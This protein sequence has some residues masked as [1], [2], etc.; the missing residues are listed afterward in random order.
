MF[1]LLESVWQLLS[2]Q[3]NGTDHIHTTFIIFTHEDDPEEWSG[4]GVVGGTTNIWRDS[5]S[6]CYYTNSSN[7]INSS[8]GIKRQLRRNTQCKIVHLVLWSVAYDYEGQIWQRNTCNDV[9]IT[10]TEELEEW[11]ID[12]NINFKKT[13]NECGRGK[14]CSEIANQECKLVRVCACDV[15]ICLCEL[16]DRYESTQ[17]HRTIRQWK[18]WVRK[19]TEMSVEKETSCLRNNV[20]SVP[21]NQ[22]KSHQGASG[23]METTGKIPATYGTM[24]PCVQPEVKIYTSIISVWE[25]G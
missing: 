4:T 15:C 14:F 21:E 11:P 16:V 24:K 13:E 6:G 12:V 18:G 5:K 2:T 9:L 19:K 17:T 8:N 10:L 20:C 25:F 1:T 3:G 23:W 7:V 22:N